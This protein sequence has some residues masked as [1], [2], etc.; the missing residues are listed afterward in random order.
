MAV[1]GA[2]ARIRS[3]KADLVILD[4]MV[5][6]KDGI[7]ICRELRQLS[8]VPI[9]ML[10]ARTDEIDRLIALEL[11]AD[12]YVCKPFSPREVVARIRNILRRGRVPPSD[13]LS[14]AELELDQTSHSVSVNGQNME[15]TPVEFRLLALL[16]KSPGRVFNRE[17][18]IEAAYTDGRIVSGR[19][20]DS[21]IKN[22]RNKLSSFGVT[23][24]HSVYGIGYKLE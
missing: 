1:Q 9:M 11:G 4:V 12:D 16:L 8:D 15:L 7:E 23:R 19:T 24:I 2:A 22:L 6:G 10:T 5:P 3:S 20:I 14:Y 18:L 21:H 13:R 17:L